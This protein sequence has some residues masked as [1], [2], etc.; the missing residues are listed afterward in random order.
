MKKRKI[1]T[2]NKDLYK[3]LNMLHLNTEVVIKN[4]EQFQIN[5]ILNNIN[6]HN[7]VITAEK[8]GEYFLLKRQG[9]VNYNVYYTQKK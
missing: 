8:I 3:K 7:Q 5:K 2:T 4:I 9:P 1:I 6:K